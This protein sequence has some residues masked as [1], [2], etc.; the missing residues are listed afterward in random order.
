M[1]NWLLNAYGKRKISVRRCTNAPISQ[2]TRKDT[3]LPNPQAVFLYSSSC[4]G[5]TNYINT[6]ARF[7]GFSAWAVSCVDTA[8]IPAMSQLPIS[9]WGIDIIDPSA[10]PPFLSIR[11][12]SIIDLTLLPLQAVPSGERYQ[13]LNFLR[14]LYSLKRPIKRR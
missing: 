14:Y 5:F 10:T 6:S 7:L 3:K 12:T 13:C 8:R 11:Q 9:L 2:H 1:I 4:L